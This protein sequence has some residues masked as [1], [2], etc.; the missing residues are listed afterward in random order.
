MKNTIHRP[1]TNERVH[2]IPSKRVEVLLHPKLRYAGVLKRSARWHESPHSHEFLEIIFIKSGY[3]TVI[4]DECTTEVRSGS[5]VI[6]NAR[7]PHNEISST[8]DPLEIYFFAVQSVSLPGLPENSLLPEDQC[9]V[10]HSGEQASLFASYFS[11]LVKESQNDLHFSKEMTESLT[12]MILILILRILSLGNK[13][14]L[15]TNEMYFKAK[16]YIDEYYASISS[17]DEVCLNVFISNY[18]LTHLF[19]LYGDKT[20]LQ[21]IIQKKLELAKLLLLST[22]LSVQDIA[23]RCG[24]EDANYFGKVFKSHEKITPAQYRRDNGLSVSSKT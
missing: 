2:Y 14:Y 20:P 15:K 10:L 12:R 11:S 8:D 5:L 9:P 17:V 1:N 16:A 3:G 4:V 13:T 22:S 18:Y 6:Y 19:R 23:V 7:T 24:Y 21:Y